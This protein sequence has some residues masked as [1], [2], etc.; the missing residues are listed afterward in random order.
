MSQQIGPDVQMTN[1]DNYNDYDDVDVPLIHKIST[2]ISGRVSGKLKSSWVKEDVFKHE[3][4][5][6]KTKPKRR[7]HVA[8]AM[9]S[10][11]RTHYNR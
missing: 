4:V 6:I 2:R 11:V 8:S 5:S 3:I 7:L 9:K 1:A 10:Y